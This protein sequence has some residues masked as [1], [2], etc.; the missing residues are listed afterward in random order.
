MGV[1]TNSLAALDVRCTCGRTI[2][3]N[4][5]IRARVVDLLGGRAKCRCK[6]W[7]ALPAEI[8]R[9]TIKNQ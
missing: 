8:F 6:S 2:F 3:S 9:L 1:S 7:V 4:G 5:V